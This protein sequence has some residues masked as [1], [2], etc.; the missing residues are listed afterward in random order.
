MKREL[1]RITRQI[2]CKKH[3]PY[4]QTYLNRF[5]TLEKLIADGRIGIDVKQK[6]VVLDS[7]IHLLYMEDD[8]KYNAFF[9][10]I[11]AYMNYRRGAIEIKEII[12]PEDRINFTVVMKHYTAFDESIGEFFDPPKETADT[13]L[14]GY[15]KN[16]R[17]EYATYEKN[18]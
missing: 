3:R 17:V 11:R 1:K 9:D 15:Y 18:E 4:V 7:S 5:A 8:Q 6:L 14:V 2:F 10:T 16:G 13:I 12:K